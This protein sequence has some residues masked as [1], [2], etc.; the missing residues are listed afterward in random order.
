MGT[1]TVSVCMTLATHLHILL[2][3]L[4]SSCTR[5][6]KNLP[7]YIFK[8]NFNIS[9]AS[10]AKCSM[11]FFPSDIL[12][13]TLQVL[14]CRPYNTNVLENSDYCLHVN[15]YYLSTRHRIYAGGVSVTSKITPRMRLTIKPQ[16]TSVICSNGAEMLF[17]I[18]F[19]MSSVASGRTYGDD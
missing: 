10:T 19:H 2:P 4:R 14:F 1:V 8:V 11:S 9:H 13:N 7:F 6:K 17:K 3:C 15:P 16:N 18:S 5:T 12:N